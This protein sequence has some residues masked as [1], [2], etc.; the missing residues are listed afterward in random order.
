MKDVIKDALLGIMI[1]L[2]GFIWGVSLNSTNINPSHAYYAAQGIEKDLNLLK[3]N[4]KD[5]KIVKA[6]EESSLEGWVK[7]SWTYEYTDEKGL[8]QI[9]S[10]V[11]SFRKEKV[12]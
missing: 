6:Q 9:R 8:V 10:G 5:V 4:Y 2:V 11:S 1:V 7:Y 3:V 12:K